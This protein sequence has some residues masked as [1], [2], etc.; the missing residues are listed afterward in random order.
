VIEAYRCRFCQGCEGVPEATGIQDWEYGFPGAFEY[1]RCRGCG[2]VQL[3]PFPELEDLEEAYRVD[4]HGYAE[5]GQ[6]S[7]LLR[8]LVGAYE[9]WVRRGLRPLVPPGARVLDVGCGAGHLLAQVRELGAGHVEGIDFSPR[10]CAPL[11][12][13]GIPAYQG[14]FLD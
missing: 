3:H 5:G 10:A 8:A 1:R 6:K 12:A 2:G 9:W 14:T 13:K 11:E 7:W 4:Y